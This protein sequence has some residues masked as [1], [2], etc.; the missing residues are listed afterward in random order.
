VVYLLTCSMEQSPSWEAN[1]WTL[2]LV[3]KFPAF[4]ESESSS[5]YPQVPATCP[6]M[7]YKNFHF[8][9]WF[10][11]FR[12]PT[13]HTASWCYEPPRENRKTH[14]LIQLQQ[15]GMDERG[16][17]T[18]QLIHLQQYGMDERGKPTHPSRFKDI[19][20]LHCLCD[21]TSLLFKVQRRIFSREVSGRNVTLITHLHIV[22]RFETCH[23][24]LPHPSRLQGMVLTEAQ[25]HQVWPYSERKLNPY[26]ISSIY[27]RRP[28]VLY[29]AVLRYEG[30]CYS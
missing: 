26:L 6:T 15:Y 3:K 7:W 22:T 11:H 30:R 24:I 13:Y 18:H 9:L 21:P 8:G 2:Q 1:Q 14:Q 23:V 4:M 12:V 16:K 27:C 19:A 17:P 29:D 25:G 10:M 28:V 20:L 5:P